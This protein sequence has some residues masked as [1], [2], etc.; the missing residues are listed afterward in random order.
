MILSNNPTENLIMMGFCVG[1]LA[2][3]G[4]IHLIQ[5]YKVTQERNRF[6]ERK[7]EE[8]QRKNQNIIDSLHE[9]EKTNKR[10]FIKW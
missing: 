5:K 2:I 1:A 3:A 4:V 8:E 9:Q 10:N 7:L 6:L